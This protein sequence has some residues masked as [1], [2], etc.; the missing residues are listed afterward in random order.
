MVLRKTL[1]HFMSIFGLEDVPSGRYPD[2]LRH[3]RRDAVSGFLVFLIALPLCMG[4][5][6]ASG[7]P[8]VSGLLTAIIGGLV[9]PFIS[10]SELTI[11]GP[12]AGMIAIVL[13]AVTAMTPETVGDPA[14]ATFEGYQKMLGLAVVAGG[15]QILLG[16]C[17]L[18]RLGEFFPVPAVHGMLVAIGLII[19]SK[20]LHVL[21]LGT[22]VRGSFFALMG[23]LPSTLKQMDAASAAI[24]IGG[25]LVLVV[26]SRVS[27]VW[28][29]R[30]PAPLWVV[31][32]AV[33]AAAITDVPQT[34]L[35]HLPERLADGFSGP[36]F[37]GLGAWEGWK[38]V[39]MLAVVG[40]L[41]SVLSANAVDLL[42]PWKRRT[43]LNRDLL[44]VGVANTI[45][46]C[47]GAIPMIS[48]IVRSSAN[49]DYGART[50]WSNFLHGMFLMIIVL[51]ASS[52][53]NRIPLSA[54][55]AL[56]V[57]TGIQLAAPAKFLAMFRTG[58]AE[59]VVFLTTVSVTLATDLL[60]GVA[61]GVVVQWVVSVRWVSGNP[62]T[63]RCRRHEE[64]GAVL[65]SLTG[66]L[67]FSNWLSLRARLSR[68]T[69][70][71]VLDVSETSLIDHSV[72]RKIEETRVAWEADGRQ[73]RTVGLEALRACSGEAFA[74]RVRAD[75]FRPA[76]SVR[77]DA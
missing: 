45:G 59:F 51:V 15:L 4:I 9:T 30:I 8:A 42:D 47:V 62:F 46:A 2:F 23:A 33:V 18:G 58:R 21:L 63:V 17:K 72:M 37:S 32:F 71:V 57:F 25:L 19:V 6:V 73:L 53:L 16:V 48:E 56:L 20:Q 44:A 7:C 68:E 54:L 50:R 65:L 13:G 35:V 40:S 24:G 5:S 41:E 31:G 70:G 29:R 67:M 77:A 12:A 61:A 69:V 22:P 55:A 52:V 1:P 34:R 66:P 39:V 64:D 26:H 60:L 38:W 76:Q 36:D 75:A 49:R 10:H 74:T 14:L 27:T 3:L 43:D 11:K 28:V